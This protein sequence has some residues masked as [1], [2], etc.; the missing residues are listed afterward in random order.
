MTVTRDATSGW[1]V[2]STL[3]EFAELFANTTVPTPASAW[4]FQ[5]PGATYVDLYAGTGTIGDL[6]GASVTSAVAVGGW[7]RVGSRETP[8][9][10]VRGQSSSG[11]TNI[12]GSATVFI[13]KGLHAAPT[14]N[15]V[16]AY[17]S[18]STLLVDSSGHIGVGDAAITPNFGSAAM[19]LT[20]RPIVH[21]ANWATSK[22]IA[23]TNQ[24]TVTLTGTFTPLTNRLFLG[25]SGG[26]GIGGADADT[27]F[28]ILWLS[29]L[30]AADAATVINRTQFGPQPYTPPVLATPS[31]ARPYRVDARGAFVPQA[32][33]ASVVPTGIAAAL[34]RYPHRVDR[35]RTFSQRSPYEAHNPVP[36][37]S[38]IAPVGGALA[39]LPD[40]PPRSRPPNAHR[41]QAF[42][43][44]PLPQGSPPPTPG[45]GPNGTALVVLVEDG[46][47][48]T[49]SWGTDV[50]PAR[51]GTEHRIATTDCPRDSYAFTANLTDAQSQAVQSAIVRRGAKAQVFLLGDM[52]E[53][54][55]ISLSSVGVAVVVPTTQYMDWIYNGARVAVMDLDTGV[56]QTGVV[57]SSSSTTIVLDQSVTVT[58]GDVIMP[59]RSVYLDSAQKLGAY[60]VNAARY[61]LVAR[62]FLYGDQNGDWT[63]HGAA[64]TSYTNPS[65]L[66]LPVFTGGNEANSLVGRALATGAEML[67][68]GGAIQQYGPQLVSKIARE[69]RYT[70]RTDADRQWLKAFLGAVVGKQKSFYLPSWRADFTVTGT[71]FGNQVITY[72]STTA[73]AGQWS[74]TGA[75]NQVQVITTTG[76]V[77]YRTIVAA[78]D[79]G[80][81]T[82]TMQL[83]SGFAGTVA[84]ISF[85]ER[86][87]LDQDEITVTWAK[88]VGTVALQAMVTKQ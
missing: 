52:S 9:G 23:Y 70:I 77:L 6:A 30:S 78:T 36:R 40:N 53:A 19:G 42:A 79:N 55:T 51:D 58:Q 73:Y 68:V 48:V 57:Q 75:H 87:R 82:E 34:A 81:G 71:S 28:A 39:E 46:A 20:V 45:R 7:S 18:G 72:N 29:A 86:C 44:G 25:N 13:L 8:E 5:E 76:A 56:Y 85:L 64:V 67:D 54:A 60:A 49:L 26:F 31:R 61:D 32:I 12:A 1:W 38:T 33:A 14:G 65:A 84:A 4:G 2:P 88:S 27:I 47:Q 74:L 17:L 11:V 66:T 22:A 59:L 69:L 16:Y 41:S 37:G 24:E 43:L 3:A 35:A 50:I 83:D 21:V 80:D 15:R 62:A 63:V 10:G